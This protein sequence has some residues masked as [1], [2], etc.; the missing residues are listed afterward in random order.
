MSDTFRSDIVPALQRAVPGGVLP[1]APLAAIARWKI[2]GS[3]A[4]LVEPASAQEVAAVFRI[5]AGRPEPLFLM[6][7]GSNLLF[8]SAGFDGVV[9]RIGQRMADV[10]VEGTRVHA[11][12]G[13]WIPRLAR[14]V[15]HR[16][17]S[18][19]EH[20]VGIPGTLGGLVLMNGG[21]RRQG[22][23]SHVA[24]V[25]C[26]D[27]QGNMLVLDQA[28]CG[29]RYRHSALQTMPA[30]IVAAELELER[31]DRQAILRD[32]VATLQSR[33]RKFPKNLPNG[34]STFL[35]DPAMYD[36]VGP[37]GAVI[38][39]LGLKG[40]QRGGAQISPLHA[41]FIVNLGG[42]TSDDVLWLIQLIRQRAFS[43]T[44]FL[45]DCEVRH[46]APDGTVRQAHQAA[47]E[48]FA[49]EFVQA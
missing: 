6:G 14:I 35:S 44:G 48:R 46:V 34:G 40:T 41:N 45:M 28:A 24:C 30:A 5:M 38:E 37:P 43:E 1:D 4:A 19:M 8:D 17:L 11:G 21:S 32:M 33:R 49:E 47:E 7:D 3:A 25:H 16:G 31:G 18:G 15:G 23:G 20:A 12:A 36:T 9:M 13:I 10:Q 42:A 2:G 26:V 27:H 29:F 39:R 22:I